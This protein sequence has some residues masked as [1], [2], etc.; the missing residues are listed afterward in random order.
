[1]NV[2]RSVVIAFSMYSR[3]PMPRVRFDEKSRSFVLLLFPIV[4]AA[5]GALVLALFA[6]LR[7]LKA[8]PL[9]SG[10]LLMACPFAVVGFIHLDGFLDTSDALGS[11]RTREERLRILKDVHAGSAA[12]LSC[13]V[14]CILQTA[15]WSSIGSVE[16]AAAVSA[17]FVLS[18]ALSALSLTILP[19]ARGRE[20]SVASF[21]EFRERGGTA[22]FRRLLCLILWIAASALL[23]CLFL[24]A[25]PE[26][27]GSSAV[28]SALSGARLLAAAIPPLA[29]ILCG[30][31]CMARMKAAFGGMTG[32]LAGY[33]LTVC[34]AAALVLT[35]LL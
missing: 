15:A 34:E 2:L 17:G 1:M 35:A 32:D 22:R 7:A 21:T 12:V 27:T 26:G 31:L 5:E 16:K 8:P 29:E 30:F 13:A 4:G 25:S 19:N 24:A 14:L 18:R 33:L 11:Y 10:A 20:S 28:P 23:M 3:I 6:L 9:L